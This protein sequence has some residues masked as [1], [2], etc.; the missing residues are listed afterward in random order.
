M[1]KRLS[2][3]IALV[4]T[5]CMLTTTAMVASTAETDIQSGIEATLVTDK[6]AYSSGEDIKVTVNVKNTN[7]YDVNDVSITVELP[8]GLTL[9]SGDLSI[10]GVGIAAGETYSKE[11]ITVKEASTPPTDKP[12]NNPTDTPTDKPSTENPNAG[13][14]GNGNTNNPQTGD[15][16]NIVLWVALMA[17]SAAGILFLTVKFR[18]KATKFLSLLLCM[19]MV[20]AIVPTGA[21]AAEGDTDTVNLTISRVNKIITVDETEFEIKATVSITISATDETDTDKD[22][23]PDQLETVLGLDSTKEDTDGDGLTDYQELS[24]V[25]TDPKI[26]DT[27]ED[28]VSDSEDD[29]DG[30]GISNIDEITLGTIPVAVDSDFDNLSDSDEMNIHKT[31]PLLSDTDGDTLS[32]SEE[33]K[34]GLNPTQASTDGKTPDNLRVFS[35]TASDE[36]KDAAL[37]ESD[38]WLNPSVSGNVIGD[39]S[40]RVTLE[41]SDKDAFS[42]NRSVVSDVIDIETSYTNPLTLTFS[43]NTAYTGDNRNLT[44]VSFDDTNRLQ[45]I[46]TVVDETAKTIYGDITGSATYFVVDLDEF[47][48]GIGIDVFSN[49]ESSETVSTFSTET[50][51]SAPIK[52]DILDNDGN[53]IGTAMPSA[54]IEK[55]SFAPI[56]TL[57]SAKTSTGATGKAD[58]VFVIDVTGSMR[59]AINNVKNNIN[60]FAD[61]LTADYNIDANF[62]LVEFQD[63]TNDGLDSTIR[64]KNMSSNWFTNVNAYK[65]E[66]NGLSLGDGGDSSETPIDGLE[67]ARRIDWR[68][69][70]SKFIVLVTDADYKND[71]QYG[72]TDMTALTNLLV[73]D[74]ITVSAITVN[75]RD[76]SDLINKTGGLYG[77]IYGNFSDIL[78]GLADKIGEVTNQGEWVFLDDYQAVRLASEGADNYGDTDG[79]GIA[80]DKELGA[81][82]TRSMVPYI[83]ALT[84]RYD[85]P[86]ELYTGKT[87]IDVYK[88][89]SNPIMVDTDYDGYRDGSDAN[90]RKWDISD[91]DLAIAA[92]IAYSN[93]SIGTKIDESS[94]DLDEGASVKEMKGWTVVDYSYGGFIDGAGED[95]FYVLALKKDDNIVIAYR[96]STAHSGF[97]WIDDWVFADVINVLTGL[98]TQSPAAKSF[99]EN[100]VNKYSSYNIY[101]CG[102]SLGGNLALSGAAKALQV[103]QSIVKRVSTF[104]GLGMPGM[105]I[106]GE[107]F[108]GDISTLSNN[109]D[110]FLDY[111]IKGDPV[112]WFES[113]NDG[114][115]FG[116]VGLTVGIGER[117]EWEQR[118]DKKHSIGNFY[119][120]ME[121]FGRPIN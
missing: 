30:D 44:I 67:N 83:A 111:E 5:I 6:N 81:K 121:P 82:E 103:N 2:V 26:Y 16:S 104:N 21:F 102:H 62:G 100:I 79:D 107:L 7:T 1:K 105:K 108:T 48:K 18:K 23:V 70:S 28:G 78:L 110:R 85:I 8:E 63:I 120:H 25:G 98:S 59:D 60:T 77:Y 65:S 91:R 95:G 94:I 61:K 73:N 42:D 88:Y 38:N 74:G 51:A 17:L 76:Y 53:V 90:P 97:D 119:Y 41:K 84:N 109:Q 20:C 9:K 117:I 118:V 24:I 68:N 3:L 71:N 56:S 93:P 46:D 34:I 80:D 89:K 49:I 64:H 4:M 29:Q 50:A 113:R 55:K 39:I 92:D 116:Y 33:I 40:S 13:A 106:F 54:E 36:I 86:A 45:V 43:Y 10:S 75:E 115:L 14:N 31:N 52:E 47:L 27:D 22:G 32:D 15:S 58:I 35:Q 96:G 99:A 112:S 101:I 12:T 11:V 19:V 66:I 37:L 114:D 57:Y 87:T 69:D 72:I